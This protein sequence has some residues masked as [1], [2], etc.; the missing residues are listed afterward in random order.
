MNIYVLRN[1]LISGM[2]PETIFTYSNF[3]FFSLTLYIS[4]DVFFMLLQIVNSIFMQF[5]KV[6]MMRN[7]TE[8]N[9]EIKTL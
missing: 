4:N 2:L 7:G 9:W 6:Y 1:R 3:S 5:M 8:R